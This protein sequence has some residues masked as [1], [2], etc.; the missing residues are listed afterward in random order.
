MLKIKEVLNAAI[1]DVQLDEYIPFSVFFGRG[2]ASPLVYWRG[3]DGKSSLV[4]IG[5]DKK[6]GAVKSVTLTSVGVDKVDLGGGLI[7]GGRWECGLPVFDTT[8][9][10]GEDDFDG[11]FLDEFDA[12]FRL[13][14]DASSVSLVFEGSAEAVRFVQSGNAIFGMSQEGQ[15]VSFNLLE[16]TEC[17]IL[18]LK[19]FKV[20]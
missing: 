2:E 5:I 13:L 14:V 7:R 1:P 4:E 12:S 18:F 8:G 3:G 10:C 20:A 19:G 11:R 16:L 17:Q 15:L 6:D 9:W